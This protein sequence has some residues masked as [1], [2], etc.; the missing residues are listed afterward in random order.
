MK[1]VPEARH[2]AAGKTRLPN[3]A[4]FTFPGLGDDLVTALDLEGVA[5]SAGSACSAG[6]Q[7]PSHV[8]LAMGYD[9]VEARTAV[10]VSLS[11][12]STPDDTRAFVDALSRIADRRRAAGVRAGERA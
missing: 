3:T 9:R 10:R 2:T 12:D 5:V 7:E 4:H 11:A 8:L 1:A 6:S